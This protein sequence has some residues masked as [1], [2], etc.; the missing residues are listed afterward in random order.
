MEEAARI[1]TDSGRTLPHLSPYWMAGWRGSKEGLGRKK[2]AK[3]AAVHLALKEIPS[4]AQ[5]MLADQF[6]GTN[7]FPHKLPSSCV[8]CSRNILKD[9]NDGYYVTLQL[10]ESKESVRVM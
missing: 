4:L 1:R 6:T 10:D 3:E 7:F 9:G 5:R 2:G 8:G